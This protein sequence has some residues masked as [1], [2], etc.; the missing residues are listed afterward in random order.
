MSALRVAE[1]LAAR[2]S[3]LPDIA[4]AWRGGGL[5]QGTETHPGQRE[6]DRPAVVADGGA[7]ERA[8]HVDG[9]FN[10]GQFP[11]QFTETPHPFADAGQEVKVVLGG[12]ELVEPRD[13]LG[14]N[15]GFNPTP[16]NFIYRVDGV[17]AQFIV[18]AGAQNEDFG[19]AVVVI[20]VVVVFDV[21]APDFV[22][23]VFEADVEVIVVP[24]QG[25]ARI[26]QDRRTGVNFNE[27]SGPGG[28]LP[29]GFIE[30]TINGD[31]FS[32]AQALILVDGRQAREGGLGKV[33]GSGHFDHRDSCGKYNNELG[34][35]RIS[36]VYYH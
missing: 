35:E 8:V 31:G 14:H 4:G 3:Y 9:V 18:D 34:K 26:E 11:I 27:G 33:K 28:A 2:G 5:S 25:D 6:L 30:F 24:K 7:I 10:T 21:R 32:C 29:H 22:V 15:E 19:V 16:E 1:V 23:F 36:F 20:N 12:E 17:D 13:I